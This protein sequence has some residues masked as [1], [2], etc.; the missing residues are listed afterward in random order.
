MKNIDGIVPVYI[1]QYDIATLKNKEIDIFIYTQAS[2]EDEFWLKNLLD[3]WNQEL[4]KWVKE[5]GKGLLVKHDV[6]GYR[7]YKSLFPEICEGGT[8]HTWSI[9]GEEAKTCIIVKEHPATK[10]FKK[11]DEFIH[12]YADHIQLATGEKGTVIIR[13]KCHQKP[14]VIVGEAGKGRYIADGMI[15]EA[16]GKKEYIPKDA[17]LKLLINYIRWLAKK[18]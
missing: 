12:T 5:E 17:E 10:G 11:G 15:D 8:W 16:V 2:F 1:S 3:K 7:A 14:V 9:S 13:D 4:I 6:V 18:S